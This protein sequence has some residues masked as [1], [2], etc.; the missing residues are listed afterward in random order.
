MVL[1]GFAR[2]VPRLRSSSLVPC[3]SA[4]LRGSSTVVAS[5]C[6]RVAEDLAST[7]AADALA[8]LAAAAVFWASLRQ[9]RGSAVDL[10]ILAATRARRSHI[11]LELAPLV[12]IPVVAELRTRPTARCLRKIAAFDVGAFPFAVLGL[13]LGWVYLELGAAV[14]PLLVVPILIARSTFA[15]YLELRPAQEQTIET[16]ILA[17]EAKDRYTAGHAQR[18]AMF[19]EYVG[20]ELG[21]RPAPHGA[22]PLRRA[23]AR[24]RQARSC[25][26][27]SSTSRAA[28]PRPSSSG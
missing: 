17:L 18:V 5:T 26:T 6:A 13:G 24:H 4:L 1:V 23:D 12:S 28:S 21:V 15:S 8:L 2:R 20:T 9:H 22:P 11:S 16:L 19:S 25:R 3:S 27:S 14:V 10:L 7:P